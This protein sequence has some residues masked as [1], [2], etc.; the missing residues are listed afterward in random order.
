VKLKRLIIQG[1]KSFKDRTTVHFDDGITGIVGPNGCG[2]SNIVDALFWVMGEQSAKHLRGSSMKDVIFSG[3]S[4]YG[5][6]AFAEASLVLGNDECKHIHIGNKVSSPTEIKLTRKLYRNGETEYRINDLPCRLRDIQEVFMDTGAGAKS[7]SIIAQGEINRLVQAKPVERR[8]MIE[9]VAGIT[10]FKVRR[11]ESLKKIEQTGANLSR[12]QDLQ[13]EIEKNLRVLQKQ[14]E[15]AER[16]RS[17]KDKIRRNEL[18]VNAHEEFEHLKAIREAGTFLSEK[19]LEIENWQTRKNTLEVDLEEERIRKSEL[20]EQIEA[21]QSE[22]NEVSKELA[23]AEEKLNYLCKSQTEKEAQ[24]ESKNKEIEELIE[25]KSERSKKLED[26]GAQ[27]QELE[28][29]GEEGFDF[30]DLEE[31]VNYLKE[32]LD[33]KKEALSEHSVELDSKKEEYNEVDQEIFRNSSK[34]EEYA[35]TLED[36]TQEIEALENQ[37]SGVNNQIANERDEVNSLEKTI[38]D[39][40]VHERELKTQIDQQKTEVSELEKNLKEKTS[41]TIKV[42][43]KLNSLEELNSSMEGVREGVG[44][45][46]KSRDD[47][48]FTLFGSLIRCEEKYTKAVQNLLSEVLDSLVSED[49]NVE[50]IRTWFEE[51]TDNSLD[52]ITCEGQEEVGSETLERIK[53]LFSDSEVI[54][55]SEIVTFEE[56]VSLPLKNMLNGFYLV[57]QISGEQIKQ[58]STSI[59]FKAIGSLDGKVAIKNNGSGRVISFRSENESDGGVVARNNRIEQLKEEHQIL[60]GECEKLEAELVQLEDVLRESVDMYEALRT[61][62]T[63]KKTDYAAKKSALESKL[64]SFETNNTRLDILQNRKK[65]ISKS[66][67]ELLE[68]EES[69]QG[70]KENLSEAIEHLQTLT[71]D[72]KEQID[73]IDSEYSEQ[74][75]ELVEKKVQAQSFE[76]RMRNSKSQMDDVEGQIERLQQK[77]ESNNEQVEKLQEDIET[78]INDLQQVEESNHQKASDL[79]DRQEVLDG[80]KDKYSTLLLGMQERENE[81]KELGKSINKTEKELVEYQVKLGKH[82]TEEEQIV[83]NIFEKYRVDLREVLSGFLEF[84]DEEKEQLNDVASIYFMETEEGPKE[85]EVESYEFN[86]RYGQDLKDC[87]H[88]LK[89][90]KSEY[91]RLGEINWQAVEDYER[92]K[93]RHDF[94]RVQ[95]GELKQSLEDLQKA[96]D[97]IDQKC[98]ERFKLAFGEVNTRFEKVFPIIFGGGNAQLK[99][100]GHIDDPECGVDIIA[101]PPG[102][103]MQNI[104]LMSGGEKAM[105]AVSLIFSIFL[106]K[107]SPFCLLDEVDAPLDDANVGRFNELLREMSSDSQFILITHNKKTMELNDTLY[108]VTMQEPGVSKAVSVQLH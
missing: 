43:S 105:T 47:D 73:N 34:L 14:A 22:Y 42:E 39:L 27:H 86:R 24:L 8:T 38:A 60:E 70:K 76:D 17:L 19:T 20:E 80:F 96:I 26:L 18:T 106:V 49:N 78:I 90:Y 48:K 36:I 37:F 3:T 23:A 89:Q 9:E 56:R 58:I 83:R 41:N 62:Y 91:S 82:K 74:K 65:E 54:P 16:A 71:D 79:E 107:P 51:N 108:G 40:E 7:Y 25:E 101:Q 59:N 32:Q 31:R 64:A 66:R 84:V 57:D 10:K 55:L 104:N 45:F 1:F 21:L 69:V 68:N 46:L 13:S 11:R 94:L 12:L 88:K 85:I 81:V 97:H 92:Q 93:L 98:R 75:D 100:V 44:N 67:L 87:S 77:I 29:Q 50:E 103:K 15:K 52:V 6:G 4:K 53:L 99:L 61:D 30:S 2:K 35:S 102:K 95:E 63:D 33:E 28:T 5:P 72:L